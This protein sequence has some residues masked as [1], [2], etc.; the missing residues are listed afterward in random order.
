[1]TPHPSKQKK[2][3]LIKSRPFSISIKHT[4][5]EQPIANGQQPQKPTLL[6]PSPPFLQSHLD[7]LELHRVLLY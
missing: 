1:M 7:E 3:H 4:F 5:E 2:A 6:L